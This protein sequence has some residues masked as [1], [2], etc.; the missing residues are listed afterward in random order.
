MWAPRPASAAVAC[1][2]RFCAETI[3]SARA[4]S[5]ATAGRGAARGAAQSLDRGL[6]VMET[7]ISLIRPDG[8]CYRGRAA[9]A[10]VRVQEPSPEAR[11]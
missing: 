8:P 5:R 1:S 3:S 7:A 10:L 6:P 9:V 2:T 4:G 11:A